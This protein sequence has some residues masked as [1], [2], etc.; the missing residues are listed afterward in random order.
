MQTEADITT[1][2]RL[3]ARALRDDYHSWHDE[4]EVVERLRDTDQLAVSLVAVEGVDIVGFIAA[5]PVDISDGTAG[6]YSIGPLVVDPDS[7]E[8]GIGTQLVQ[9]MIRRLRDE[10]AAGA[11]VLGAPDFYGHFGFRR[12]E[13]AHYGP[14]LRDRGPLLALPFTDANLPTGT[15]TYR[16]KG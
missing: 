6:W 10:G 11:V 1:I 14:R 9:A 7:R 16:L 15:I 4:H 12:P 8:H 3:I 5:C 2:R 13:H